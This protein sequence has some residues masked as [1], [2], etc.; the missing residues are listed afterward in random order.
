MNSGNQEGTCRMKAWQVT[1]LG[2]PRK[3]LRQPEAPQPSPGP[4]R[5]LVRV[6]ASALNFPDV[7][8]CLGLYQVSPPLPFTPGVE[9]WGKIAGLGEGVTGWSLGE[10]VVGT[11]ILPG[12]A[13]AE[14]VLMD[15]ADTFRAP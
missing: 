15:A 4:G 6:I 2:E 9:L 3:A 14:Y 8:L 5:L 10:R 12:G 13:F 11:P 1:E 7:L